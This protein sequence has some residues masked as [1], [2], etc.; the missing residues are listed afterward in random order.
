VDDGDRSAWSPPP[1]RVLGDFLGLEQGGR[2]LA[3][4]S[5]CRRS[6]SRSRSPTMRQDPLFN[7]VDF[8][9]L[10]GAKVGSRDCGSPEFSAFKLQVGSWSFEVPS[11]PSP[12]VALGAS[13]TAAPDLEGFLPVEERGDVDACCPQSTLLR[14][15]VGPFGQWVNSVGGGGKGPVLSSPAFA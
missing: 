2:G 12:P 7:F 9:P 11:S 13:S 10:S 5:E 1:S 8:P 15:G 14:A 6:S 4:R 3:G